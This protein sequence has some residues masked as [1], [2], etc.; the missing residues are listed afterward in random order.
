MSGE[1]L[2]EVR[3]FRNGQEIATGVCGDDDKEIAE[4]I[5]GMKGENSLP[6]DRFVVRRFT[7]PGRE[8]D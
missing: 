7:Q 6:D 2:A 4:L 1:R 8:D 5:E 3:H